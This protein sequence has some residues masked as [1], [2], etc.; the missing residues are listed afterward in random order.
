MKSP[1]EQIDELNNLIR[2]LQ[3]LATKIYAGEDVPAYRDVNRIISSLEIS[4]N[5]IIKGAKSIPLIDT[6]AEEHDV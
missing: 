3:K 4:K 2:Q 6:L 1:L 5:N